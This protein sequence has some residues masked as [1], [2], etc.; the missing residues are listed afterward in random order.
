MGAIAAALQACQ[1][2]ISGACRQAARDAS[3]ATLLAVSKT[4]P[5]TAIREA[6]D[7]GQRCFG[8]SYV[9]EAVGK[10]DNLAD[11]SIEWHFIGPLQSNK[12]RPVAE[13]FQWVHGV[14]SLKIA[15][16]LSEQRPGHQPPLQA[17]IQVNVSGEASKHGVPPR[18]ALDLA[19]QVAGLQN[20]RLR[21]F[22]AIP[23]P[24][25]DP[26]VQHA[27]FRCLAD[28]L[29]Q[30]R[31][32]GL[33]LDTLS[34]GMSADLETAIAEGSTLVRVG[35]AIFGTRQYTKDAAT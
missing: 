18:G 6:W 25:P 3:C 33:E 29:A 32:A 17:C 21:G 20:L 13:R 7:A 22:M 28:L 5:A 23:E 15:R 2:R 27:R 1:N 31:G 8:E 10:M 14:E 24:S 11:L 34:M 12:T 9:Q 26:A 35:T 16:R 30:A 4:F 19:R